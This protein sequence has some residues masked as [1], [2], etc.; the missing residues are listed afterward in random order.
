MRLFNQE[1][2]LQ[3][4]ILNHRIIAF[5]ALRL[6]R[7]TREYLDAGCDVMPQALLDTYEEDMTNPST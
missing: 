5:D 6:V 4:I 7:T 1:L 3:A 2:C